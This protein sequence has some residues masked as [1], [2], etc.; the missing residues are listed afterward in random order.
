MEEGMTEP[1]TLPCDVMVP[2]ATVIPKGAPLEALLEAACAAG[3]A[4]GPDTRFNDPA[5]PA[6]HQLPEMPVQVD[7][8]DYQYEGHLVG[9]AFKRAGG[10][11]FVVEDTLGRL[12][13]HR[14]DQIGKPEGWLP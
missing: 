3:A 4:E 13:F 7:C 5:A 6:V 14:A 8:S 9:V 10:V 11:R 1:F 12:A 2:P